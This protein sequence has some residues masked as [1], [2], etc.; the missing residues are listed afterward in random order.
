MSSTPI[1]VLA[2]ILGNEK[3]KA[4][5][6]LDTLTGSKYTSKF[7]T[8]CA[9]LNNADI[10][11]LK[12]FGT[13][14]SYGSESLELAVQNAE[15][16][17][18]QVFKKGARCET[19]DEMRLWYYHHGNILTLCDLPPTSRS[20]R[21]HI[22][23]AL[24]HT[25]ISITCLYDI[26]FQL[27]IEPENFGYI[28]TEGYLKPKKNIVLYPDENDLVP[29][30]NCLKCWKSCSC[31]KKGVPCCTFCKCK[32]TEEQKCRNMNEHHSNCTETD[33]SE[34]CPPLKK[35]KLQ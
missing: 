9:A 30:C 33:V 13:V 23:R 26:N 5:V 2:D 35:I 29:S 7:G 15:R 28:I 16:Y 24:Y 12:G 4:M 14:T 31:F 18:V 20:G 17:L 32:S 34:K 10:S 8:K 27:S 22:L 6:A 11:L 25:H 19:L 1:H 3:C 21:E